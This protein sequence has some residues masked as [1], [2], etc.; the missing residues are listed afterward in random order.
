MYFEELRDFA[1]FFFKNIFNW[2]FHG[3]VFAKTARFRLLNYF[4]GNKAVALVTYYFFVLHLLQPKNGGVVMVNFYSDYIKCD[5]GKTV[6]A[7]LKH[8]AGIFL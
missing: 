2:S 6:A 5:S 7:T 3:S 4:N 8:V 1:S